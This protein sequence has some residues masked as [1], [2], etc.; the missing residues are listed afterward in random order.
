MASLTKSYVIETLEGRVLLDGSAAMSIMEVDTPPA[1]LAPYAMVSSA[2]VV[3]ASANPLVYGRSVT[4]TATVV[5][6]GSPTGTVQFLLNGRVLGS[7]VN[8]V[9]GKANSVVVSALSVGAYTIGAAYSGDENHRSSSGTLNLNVVIPTDTAPPSPNPSAWA[10]PPRA[11]DPTQIT[12]LAQTASDSNGVEY[13]FL[14]LTGGGHD[15]D[16]QSLPRYTDTDLLPGRSYS[17]QVVTRDKSIAQNTGLASIAATATTPLATVISRVLRVLG[18]SAADQISLSLSGNTWTV[19]Q[20]NNTQ[21]FTDGI[22]RVLID[23]GT[24]ADTISIGPGIGRVTVYGGAGNDSITGGSL[25]DLIYG[26]DGEDNIDGGDSSDTIYGNFGHDRLSGGIGRD[27]ILAG[28]GDDTVYGDGGIDMLYSGD[29]SDYVYGGT[30]ADYIEGRGK[31]DTIY[32][33]DGND[34]IYGGAGADLIYGEEGEDWLYAGSSPLFSDTIDGGAG[35]DR[36][37]ADADDVLS[38]VE[39]PL[40]K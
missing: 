11:F 15:S 7:P 31:A 36:Y 9:G 12:M 23:G 5:S 34:T 13:R 25:A 22:D 29:G 20:G 28:L 40:T 37:E 33:G 16:W 14:C 19:R 10:E 17:Y 18:S 38:R 26:G 39:V 3:T 24:G 32:G 35:I 27:S 8:L 2:T 30:E 6:P 4:F 1:M 21:Q